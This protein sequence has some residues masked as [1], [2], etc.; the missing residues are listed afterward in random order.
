MS[1][2]TSATLNYALFETIR[3]RV[4]AYNE[5]GWTE[6][7]SP[8]STT[9]ATARTVPEQMPSATI[10]RG[11]LT[12]ETQIHVQWTPLVTDVEIGDTAILSYNLRF[13][14][15]LGLNVY[16][17]LV[18]NPSD[19]PFIEFIVT[20]GITKDTDYSFQVRAR[21]IYGW[22]DSFSDPAVVIASSDVPAIMD[23][24][25]TSY[26]TGVDPTA[27]KVEW[28]SPYDNSEPVVDF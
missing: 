22:A 23:A 13:D 7:P 4:S 8:T 5:K 27:V 16:V 2:F 20:D 24:L 11:S 12:S 6:S 28:V 9:A 18:G 3:V 19:F 10:Q 26:D 1:R 14:S 25:V 21:N 17:D 15:G